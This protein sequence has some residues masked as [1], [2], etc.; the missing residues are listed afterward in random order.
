M[1]SLLAR[2]AEVSGRSFAGCR[3]SEWE[4]R[5]EQKG[6]R[7]RKHSMVSGQAADLR[8][9]LARRKLDLSSE[10]TGVHFGPQNRIH[11]GVGI[12]C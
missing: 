11:H 12:N 1:T 5:R 2:A 4:T 6:V 10:G 7:K 8:M 3:N 9:A